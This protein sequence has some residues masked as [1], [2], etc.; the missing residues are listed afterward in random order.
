MSEV[1]HLPDL[2]R[3]YSEFYKS[4]DGGVHRIEISGWPRNRFEASVY[5]AGSAGKVI[6]IGCGNGQ[7]L[8]S[9]EGRFSTL[10][11][12]ELSKKRSDDARRNLTGLGAVILYANVEAGVPELESDC[13]DVVI[14]S[15]VLEHFVDVFSAFREMTRILKPGGRLIL[16]TPNFAKVKNRIKLLFGVFGSTSATE[17]GFGNN[18]S[19]Q[20]LDGG[21]LH[22]FTFSM[23]DRL[24][25]IF[26][27]EQVK[28]YG[29]G[30]FGRLHNFWPSLL[31]PSCQIVAMKKKY[32]TK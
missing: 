7:C 23:L 6:D 22:Y 32:L 24:C 25:T 26:G 3:K 12:I 15:D 29:F 31:S 28:H 17:E 5:F 18:D 10:Y 1:V 4:P 9:L 13:F 2:E 30:R 20:L 21:H 16:N 14:C 11:G 27:Y 19:K 8:Y